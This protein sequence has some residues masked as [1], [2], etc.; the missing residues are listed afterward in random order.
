M[1]IELNIRTR[2]K[3]SN[4]QMRTKTEKLEFA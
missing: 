4:V 2:A 3:N 1:Y